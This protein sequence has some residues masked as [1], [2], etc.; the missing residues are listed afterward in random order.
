MYISRYSVSFHPPRYVNL[1][2]P[3]HV[4]NLSASADAFWYL[5]RVVYKMYIE[6]MLHHESHFEYIHV[7][8][9]IDHTFHSKLEP[10]G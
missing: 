8:D 7:L 1:I 4:P 9:Y 6:M 3:S 5:R 2:F 10:A